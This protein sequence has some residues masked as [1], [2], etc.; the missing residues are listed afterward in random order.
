MPSTFFR[1]PLAALLPRLLVVAYDWMACDRCGQGAEAAAVSAV[2]TEV[3]S[4]DAAVI[5]ATGT[6]TGTTGK[7]F[8]ARS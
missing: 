6:V 8:G 7:T 3:L 5:V 1:S 4:T 2:I